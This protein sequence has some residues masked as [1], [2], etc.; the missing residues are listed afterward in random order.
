MREW[1]GH[2]RGLSVLFF[3]EM[4]ERFSYYGMRALLLLFMVAPIAGGGLGFTTRR[5]ATIYG[6]YTMAVYASSIPGGWLADRILGHYRSVLSGSVLITLGHFSMA[7]SSLPTFF[8]G[9][10][11]IVC[12][13]GMLKPN[14]STMV[15]FLYKPDDARR[16]AGFSLFYMGINLG[17]MT[18]P[19]VC[20]FLGQKF[21]WH[22]GFAAAGFGMLIGMTQYILGRKHLPESTP[23]RERAVDD[24]ANEPLTPSDWKRIGAICVLFVFALI[25]WSVFEQ[26]GSTLTL[27][28]DHHTR[29]SLLGWTFPSSW[30]QS[31]QPLFVIALAPVFALMWTRLGKREPS[32]ATKFTL[33]L[34]LTAIGF[35]II[36]PAA[37]IAETQHVR[38]SPVWL[39]LLYFVHTLGELCLS[40]VGLSLVTKISPKKVVGLMMGFWFLAAS[41]GNF[42][43]GLIASFA[44]RYPLYRI[45]TVDFVLPAV[46][47]IA[48]AMLIR[49]LRSLS[50]KTPALRS[51]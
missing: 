7:I 32:S 48:L 14:V 49:P 21:N 3:T 34:A 24:A 1:L 39:T 43:A 26:A 12:G 10:A 8:L 51:R 45:F 27:F 29:L 28:A 42:F 4:W 16:D 9:L 46:G 33:G 40:P 5:A 38:V 22:L 50:A 13:T 17:A 31:E 30:F 20:G 41:L 25:F 6:L 18:A 19:L 36:I 47:A 37:R 35:A 15:G 2:P 23:M 44:D 11:L